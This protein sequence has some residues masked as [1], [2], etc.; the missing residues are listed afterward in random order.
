MQFKPRQTY[1]RLSR[2]G[3][4]EFGQVR[5]VEHGRVIMDISSVKGRCVETFIPHKTYAFGW[6]LC[7]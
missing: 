6:R 5:C 7:G 2:T 1:V 3:P 4:C